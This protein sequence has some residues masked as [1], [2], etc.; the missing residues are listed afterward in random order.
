MAISLSGGSSRKAQ[1]EMLVLGM[2]VDAPAVGDAAGQIMGWA[3]SGSSRMVCA[4][5]VHMTMEANDDP[6]FQT[7]VNN[8]DLVLPDGMPLVWALRMLG[9]S[10]AARIRVSPDFLIELLVRAEQRGLKLG[11]YGGTPGT[12]AAFRQRLSRDIPALTVSYAYSPPFRPLDPL[13]DAA[14]VR[15]ICASG[16]QLLLVGIGCPKQ[17]KWMAE[18]RDVLPCVMIGVGAAFD[19]FGGQTREAPIWM[20]R[21]ALEWVFRLILEPRRLWRRQ[22]KHNPRFVLLFARQLLTFRR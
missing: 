7:A 6:S 14:V 12:L 18:H 22:L 9:S 1:A 3:S 2:R 19:L 5:N 15:E 17:E 13:E 8:A 20:Q 21:L 11:L 10:Q 4:A 16:T